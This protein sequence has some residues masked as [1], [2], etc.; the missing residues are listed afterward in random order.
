MHAEVF[1]R[2][3]TEVK[4]C[5]LKTVNEIRAQTFSRGGGRIS[6]YAS[7]RIALTD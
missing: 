7:D 1:Q 3:E 2:Q 4:E 6:L 5:G